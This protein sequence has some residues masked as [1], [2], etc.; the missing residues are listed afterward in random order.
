MELNSKGL[1][2]KVQ[3]KK[4]KVVAFCSRLRLNVKLGSFTL[5]CA[6]TAEKCTKKRDTRAK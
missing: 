3:E 2:Q 6:K 1:D 4:K 5:S